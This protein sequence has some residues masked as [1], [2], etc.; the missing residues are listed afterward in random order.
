MKNVVYCVNIFVFLIFLPISILAQGGQID[1][2]D[3]QIEK[4]RIIIFPN[5]VRD[6]EKLNILDREKPNTKQTFEFKPIEYK[7]PIVSPNVKASTLPANP[8]KPLK[9]NYIKGGIGNYLTSNLEIYL[10]SL[11]HQKINYGL[12]FRHLSSLRGAVDGENS[13]TSTNEILLNGKYLARIGE[14]NANLGYKRRS[15]RFYGYEEL[16]YKPDNDSIRQTFQEIYGSWGVHFYHPQTPLDV[17]L[18][19]Q[20]YNLSTHLDAKEWNIGINTFTSYELNEYTF[21]NIPINLIFNRYEDSLAFNRHLFSLAPQYNWKKDKLNFEVGANLTYTTDTTS[22][23]NNLQAYPILKVQYEL[24]ENNLIGIASITG[25]LQ[26]QTLRSFSEE[27][28]FL[29]SNIN[30]AHTNQI[31]KAL[32]GLKTTPIQKVGI[33]ISGG[34]SLVKNLSFFVNDITNIAH[35]QLVYEKETSNIL[36]INLDISLNLARF[37]C[38]MSST[39]QHYDL[40]NINKAWHRPN[41]TN[42]LTAKYQFNDKLLLTANALHLS[43]INARN[44]NNES[45]S[46]DAIFDLNFKG[47]Y[48]IN[49]KIS[50]FLSLNNVFSQKY[51]RYWQYPNQGILILIGGSYQF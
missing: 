33:G 48:I 36:D 12:K 26:Q 6:F 10:N 34:Y 32:L 41:F 45:F 37:Q 17:S 27:N 28:P 29:A 2:K 24:I 47:E 31:L 43:G 13:A 40:K 18:G 20:F 38:V 42:K 15:V 30:L 16:S 11:R 21:I 4:E 39:Y 14:M 25:S 1:E 35:F 23:T 51:E 46:M 50:T 44:I 5:A 49:E 8:L 3:F 9:R 7:L 19:V 22:Q